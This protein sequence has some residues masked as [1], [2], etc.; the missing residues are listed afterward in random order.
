MTSTV[1]SS[2]LIY[3]ITCSHCGLI[4]VD[5]RKGQLNKRE[6]GRRYQIV[7][8]GK[9][10]LFLHFELPN[11]SILSIGVI[12]IEKIYHHTN[13]LNLSTHYHRERKE[14]WI[15]ELGTASHYG[16]NDNVYSFGNH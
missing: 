4:Y 9:L 2:N 6:S 16:C 12:V 5:E 1:K 13:S 11:H 3:G 14:F 7:N 15:K 8:N 10:L